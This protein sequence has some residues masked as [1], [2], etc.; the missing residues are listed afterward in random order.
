MFM[1]NGD[2]FKREQYK[3]MLREAEKQRLINQL[4]AHREGAAVWQRAGD[5]VSDVF[6]NVKHAS[7]VMKLR[8]AN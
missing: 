7:L 1:S 2:G 6:D 3:D 5:F 4:L 8:N